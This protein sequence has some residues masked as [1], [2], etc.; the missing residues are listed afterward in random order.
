MNRLVMG[1][2]LLAV[3]V[4]AAACATNGP[5]GEAGSAGGSVPLEGTQWRLTELDGRPARPAGTDAPNLRL[6]A[7]DKRAGGNT[8]CNSFGGEYTLS[9]DSLRF[10]ML[11]STRRACT[12]EAL[13]AQE[14]SYLTALGNVRT[15]RIT[16][17]SLELSGA[18]GV[19]A[20][21]V[22]QPAS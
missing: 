19:V 1:C 21:F 8:G 6:N 7:A 16:G 11:A 20:R 15:W 17:D 4:L 12:D 9:G 5:A 14:A 3:A 18:S 13:N 2:A 10:G 22:A